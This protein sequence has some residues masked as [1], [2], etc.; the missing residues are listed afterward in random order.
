MTFWMTENK[1]HY[2]Y[3][4]HYL[5]Y[6]SEIWDSYDSGD[7]DFCLLGYDTI[8]LVY[9]TTQHHIPE[10]SN[11]QLLSITCYQFHWDC[12]FLVVRVAADIK[13]S[14]VLHAFYFYNELA[15]VIITGF[16]ISTMIN[17]DMV[18]FCDL[19]NAIN[20]VL[21]SMGIYDF[22]VAK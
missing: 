2:I 21:W 20:F 14:F 11:P 1:T 5:H 18:F 13:Y 10:D 12:Y 3:C 8:V 6:L 16:T 17:T 9:Q 15:C 7:G 4:C 19:F 22:T